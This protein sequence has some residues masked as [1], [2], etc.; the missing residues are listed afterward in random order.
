MEDFVQLTEQ[1]ISRLN[2]NKTNQQINAIKGRELFKQLRINR[3]LEKLQKER[4]NLGIIEE[5][6]L[7]H[8]E[9]LKR[10]KD[11]DDLTST[12]DTKKQELDMLRQRRLEEFMTGLNNISSKLKEIYQVSF[13]DGVTTHP[14]YCRP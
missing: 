2:L 13:S 11:L 9:Y 14:S 8:Q 3:C 10:V 7:K 5:Y 1:E 12:R 6:Q 4:P